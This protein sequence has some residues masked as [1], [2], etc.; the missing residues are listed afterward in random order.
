VD[1]RTHQCLDGFALVPHHHRGHGLDAPAITP[2]LHQAAPQLCRARTAPAA[3]GRAKGGARQGVQ[4]RG[5]ARGA[6]HRTQAT[7]G[8]RGVG[9]EHVAHVVDAVRAAARLAR[10]VLRRQASV[11]SPS[12]A[13]PLE[14]RL[15]PPRSHCPGPILHLTD[16][17]GGV[18]ESAAPCV[19]FSPL[20]AERFLWLTVW[21]LQIAACEMAATSGRMTA[22]HMINGFRVVSVISI[23]LMGHFPSV[24]GS[25]TPC[26][27]I[28]CPTFFQ[29]LNLYILSGII[30]MVVQTAILRRDVVR[31]I[32]RLPALPKNA[33]MKS[34]TFKES[35]D[36]LK[37]W[38]RE[39]NQ[40]AR[41]RA[42]KDRKW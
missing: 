25:S 13:V 21:F 35:I 7:Q 26:H 36:H 28:R 19:C 31:R 39:Q 37:V 3:S 11:R 41:E 23:P 10:D 34:V 22:V 32:L 4:D 1:A 42:L 20:C 6:T 33:D 27:L 30:T 15:V 17:F 14:R 18:H 12:R 2:V 5:Q 9:R 38:F 8:V 40:T 16:C 29:G 24:C